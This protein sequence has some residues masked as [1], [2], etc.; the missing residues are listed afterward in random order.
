MPSAAPRYTNR[1]ARRARRAA[2]A[3]L[4]AVFAFAMLQPAAADDDA[5]CAQED[6]SSLAVRACTALLNT[7]ELTQDMRVRY[8]VRRGQ[9]WFKE[10]EPKEAIADFTHAIGIDPKHIYAYASRAKAHTAIGEH[11][12]AAEDWGAIIAASPGDASAEPL[13]L[14]RAAS[15]LAAGDTDAALASY[16]KAL[17]LNP[18]S[19]NA[20]I[21]RG[22]VY[23]A[24]NDKVKALAEFAAAE[25]IDFSTTSPFLARGEAAEKWGDTA[26]AI[27]NYK[28]VVRNNTRSAGPARQALRRLGIDNV[29]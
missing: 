6:T 25:K 15:L 8:L 5:D 22:N 23:A 14:S 27:E 13:H 18:K 9:A 29:P 11:K 21:G 28:V 20:Y 12:L 4:L 24:L 16:T 2:A 19:I 7:S 1:I 17:T 26:L 3:Q 10:E